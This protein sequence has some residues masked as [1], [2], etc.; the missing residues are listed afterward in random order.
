MELDEALFDEAIKSLKRKPS[1][2]SLYRSNEDWLKSVGIPESVISFFNKY[3]FSS[4]AEF[5]RVSFSSPNQIET[6]NTEE[7]NRSLIANG[8]LIIGS[9]A[10][11]DPVV[12]DTMDGKVGF[13]SHDELWEEEVCDPRE[14]LA[15]MDE[16]IGSFYKN[17]ACNPEFPVDYYQALEYKK[18]A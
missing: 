12:L 18:N 4:F 10:N 9:S 16:T 7:E 5:G 17:A 6:E 1:I 3:A 14:V 13:V 15:K 8:L 2:H 11:G